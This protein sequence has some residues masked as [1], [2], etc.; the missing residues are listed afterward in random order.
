MTSPTAPTPQP[1]AGLVLAA[2]AGTR[3][4]Q[5]KAL[6]VDDRGGWLERATVLLLD[7]GCAPVI[8]VLGAAADE[9]RA[10]LPADPRVSVVVAEHWER[11]L[12]A[13]LAAGLRA[14]ER[15]DAASTAVTLVDLPT[16]GL[17][18]VERMLRPEPRVDT[19]RQARWDGR[20]GHPVVIGR[21]H[22]AALLAELSGDSGA[23]SY[24]QRHGA[25]MVDCS[26]LGDG[27]D[28]DARPEHPTG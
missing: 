23:R 3:M 20:P 7:A 6:V 11:G 12:S 5:P 28:V 9:A 17:A 26:D 10:L 1:P 2:G 15:T 18:A 14:A 21:T 22:W 4:G 13:S 16:L 25:D 19:L 24:L 8:V 27:M